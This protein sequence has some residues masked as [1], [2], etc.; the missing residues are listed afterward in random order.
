M[1]QDRVANKEEAC[2]RFRNWGFDTVE[3]KPEDISH[4]QDGGWVVFFDGEYS[5]GLYM[6]VRE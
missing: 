5:H 6:E 1:E 2:D 4:L 3:L